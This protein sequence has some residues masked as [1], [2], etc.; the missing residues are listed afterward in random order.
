[1]ICWS[2]GL[3]NA[4]MISCALHETV[5]MQT[6]KQSFI[7]FQ[8]AIPIL[9]FQSYGFASSSA[10]FN[11]ISNLMGDQQPGYHQFTKRHDTAHTADG[12]VPIQILLQF[13]FLPADLLHSNHMLCD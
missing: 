1:M 11:M 2:S 8:Y 12:W 6:R 5:E 7:Y 10:S 9:V 13:V 3:A 4:S